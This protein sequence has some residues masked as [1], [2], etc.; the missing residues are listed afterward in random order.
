VSTEPRTVTVNVLVTKPLEIDEPDWCVDPHDGAQFKQDLTHNGPK[1]AAS[2]ET[3]HGT[4]EY[5]QA[6]ISHAPY[7]VLA[8]EPLPI[9]GVDIGGDAVSLDPDG[10]RAFTAATRAHLDNLDRLADEAEHIHGGGQ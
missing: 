6:W 8:P 3:Q 1:I 7:G 5:L 9:L 10:L 4:V 2:F